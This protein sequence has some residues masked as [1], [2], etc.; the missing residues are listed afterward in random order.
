MDYTLSDYN[1]FLTVKA[2]LPIIISILVII[3]LVIL[4]ILMFYQISRND[5]FMVPNHA[6][7]LLVNSCDRINR[8]IPNRNGKMDR[9]KAVL[10]FHEDEGS[11]MVGFVV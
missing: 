2:Y 10:V 1:F 11:N 9:E 8:N 6:N 5:H 3:S 4:F 7:N